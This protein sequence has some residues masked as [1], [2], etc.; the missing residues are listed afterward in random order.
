MALNQFQVLQDH[1]D[2]GFRILKYERKFGNY[3]FSIWEFGQPFIISVEDGEHVAKFIETGEYRK[4]LLEEVTR[5]IV[6]FD[7]VG[8]SKLENQQQLQKIIRLQCFL[9]DHRLKNY[10]IAE[11]VS[12]G[13][14]AIISFSEAHKL[15]ALEF[16]R[17]LSGFINTFNDNSRT[18]EKHL[19][20]RTG[21]NYGKVHRFT[22]INKTANLIGDGVNRAERVTSLGDAGQILCTESV[23][24]MHM[25]AKTKFGD[26]FFDCGEYLD[27]HEIPFHVFN[28]CG[29][30]DGVNMGISRPPKK[31]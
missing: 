18:E 7:I 14:G 12:L 13:D 6:L 25:E 1:L 26:L 3:L 17:D 22:D 20:L 30:V 23:S 28:I 29:K 2:S 11:K 16:V 5:C 8:F 4:Y 31:K 15:R 27:K 9:N 21:I 24:T 10:D 19:R